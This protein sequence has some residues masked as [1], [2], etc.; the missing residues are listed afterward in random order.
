MKHIA[1]L[2]V[3]ASNIFIIFLLSLLT[4]SCA[5]GE[6][7]NTES[8]Q[9]PK[10]ADKIELAYGT[11]TNPKISTEGGTIT[12]SFN[13]STVWTAQAINDRADAWCTVS[14]ANGNAG[15]G[16][17]TITAKENTDTDE[18]SASI[19]IKA[20]TAQQTIK[21]TQKQKD[22]LTITASTFEV[23]AE[24]KD[25]DIEVKSNVNVKYKITDECKD[26]IKHVSTKAIKTSTLT[27]AVSKN[28]N[29]QKREGKIIIGE[30]ALADTIRIFQASGVPSIVLNKNEYTAKSQGEDFAIDV[31]SN[32]DVNISIIH[33]DGSPVWLKKNTTKAMSTNTY[34]FTADANNEY[35]NR[36]AKIIFTNKENNLADTVKVFQL[37]KDAIILSQSV[38][39]I[40]NKGGNISINV[41]ANIKY[42]LDINVDWITQITTRTL[43]SN[44]IV[45][46]VLPNESETDRE[47]I[48]T[49]ISE[50]KTIEQKIKIVQ[51]TNYYIPTLIWGQTISQVKEFMKNYSL[52][53]EN[54]SLL[55]FENSD[56]YVMIS[57]TFNRGKLFEA[58]RYSPS[59]Y[60]EN[61]IVIDKYYKI[62]ETTF[63]D[64]IE[65]PERI[66]SDLWSESKK[67]YF[68]P[69]ISRSLSNREYNGFIWFSTE[70][71]D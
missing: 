65:I 4:N 15:A 47:A 7:P 71:M 9:T 68:F 69:V 55:I 18:R 40:D 16:T 62:M 32:V 61:G 50:D 41:A 30:G 26:W 28:E 51:T 29:L 12:I 63:N 5:K 8:P 34:W 43:V 31:A 42:T 39:N 35:D 21:V 38:Y 24:G 70:Y 20:G 3:T 66:G 67:T 6:I 45:F 37:Q 25:I 46:N 58:R 17:I 14:P 56:P 22:A 11:D 54:E 33:P 13:A 59:E 44:T 52:L 23:P 27:F 1:P 2:K 57:Y 48:I 36:E 64:F 53:Y 19:N 49:F 10:P 60:N